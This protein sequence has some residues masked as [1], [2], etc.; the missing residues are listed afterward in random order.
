MGMSIEYSELPYIF[1]P[2]MS[3]ITQVYTH[4]NDAHTFTMSVNERL[5][6]LN[7]NPAP[8]PQPTPEPTP[9]A[10]P[11]Q[12]PLATPPPPTPTPETPVYTPTMD[13]KTRKWEKAT[14][15]ISQHFIKQK[16]KVAAEAVERF[17]QNYHYQLLP[18]CFNQNYHKHNT[19][20]LARYMSPTNKVGP[21]TYVVD[22]I[23]TMLWREIGHRWS[24]VPTD[25]YALNTI[26]CKNVKCG[27]HYFESV[28]L[29]LLTRKIETITIADGHMVRM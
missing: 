17:N 11:V 8:I 4:L 2:K 10:S 22:F 25:S 1:N 7:Y 20:S 5:Q 28:R 21:R 12:S 18:M 9:E 19:K 16:N 3:S 15:A 23:A 27:K 24:Y 6:R 26:D 29:N 13:D 14:F